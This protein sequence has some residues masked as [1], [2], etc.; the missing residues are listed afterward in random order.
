MVSDGRCVICN[1]RAEENVAHFPVGC[2][3]LEKDRLGQLDDV[4]RILGAR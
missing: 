4:C 3:E 1:N 2:E